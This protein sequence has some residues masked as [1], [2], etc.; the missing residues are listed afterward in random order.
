V[1]DPDAGSHGAHQRLR[2]L[3]Y[4]LS[5]PLPA[6]GRYAAARRSGQLLF[7]SG[8]TGRTSSGPAVAGVVGADVEIST[9]Q[10]SARVAAVNLLSVVDDAVGLASVSLVHLR[11]YVRAHADFTD[12]PRVIDAASELLDDVLSDA[13]RHARAAVGVSSLPGGAVV[14]LEAVF[15]VRG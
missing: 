3:G 9:A 8:H 1:T 2:Q 15:E 5:P 4:E 12:H 11:G 14:E 7:V 6:K 10:E 13:A